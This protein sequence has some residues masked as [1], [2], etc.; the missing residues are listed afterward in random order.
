[1]ESFCFV[2][3][4]RVVTEATPAGARLPPARRTEQ[5][6]TQAAAAAPT[7][8]APG[9]R[10]RRSTCGEGAGEGP[11]GAGR[12]GSHV[13]GREASRSAAQRKAP[14]PNC[15]REVGSTTPSGTVLS[16]QSRMGQ[17]APS[18]H[19]SSLRAARLSPVT[20]RLREPL[21]M[22]FRPMLV[23][24]GSSTNAPDTPYVFWVFLNVVVFCSVSAATVHPGAERGAR[25]G[26]RGQVRGQGRPRPAP[27]SA[28]GEAGR[29]TAAHHGRHVPYLYDAVGPTGHHQSPGYV[30]GHVGDVMLSFVK[31]C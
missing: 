3:L 24:T 19:G 20:P 7:S 16:S 28:R 23:P 6:R 25:E 27:G 8:T 10:R 2:L 29:Q 14:A 18:A 26:L 30:H 13:Q 31:G 12:G 11:P 4:R 1:M 5:Q 22:S 17:T 15:S 9:T 21:R